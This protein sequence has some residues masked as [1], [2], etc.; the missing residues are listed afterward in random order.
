VLIGQAFG[1]GDL[2]R[3]RAVAGASIALAVFF[4][5]AIA[6]AGRLFAA[7]RVHFLG[8]PADTLHDP[9]AHARILMITEPA[10]FLFILATSILRGVGDSVTPLWTLSVS[11]AIG[12]IVTPALIAGW[13]GLPRLGVASA[14]VASLVSIVLSMIWLTWYLLR[15][16]HV[17]APNAALLR[18]LRLDWSVLK[19]VLRIGVP[20]GLQMVIRAIAELVLLGLA[21]SYGTTPPA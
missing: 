17:L 8:P 6:V 19:T 9:T 21:N 14:A 5:T 7:P 12:L 15:R 11:T 10:F 3:V 1:R 18:H 20:T 4:G 13:G 16:D 2:D